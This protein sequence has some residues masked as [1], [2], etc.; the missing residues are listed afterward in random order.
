MFRLEPAPMNVKFVV[1]GLTVTVVPSSMVMPTR[2]MFVF[3]V[4]VNAAVASLPAEKTAVSPLALFQATGV[5]VPA[6]SP[7]LAVPVPHVPAGLVA[8]VPGLVVLDGSQYTG[9]PARA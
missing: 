7:Q 2:L 9:P 8:P 6:A 4:T 3:V 5:A 1:A